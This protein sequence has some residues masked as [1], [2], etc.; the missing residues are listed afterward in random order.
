VDY[1]LTV[2]GQRI[3]VEIKYRRHIGFSDTLGLRSFVEKAHYNAPFGLLVTMLDD[4]KVEDPRIIPLP[5]STLL[6]L[7]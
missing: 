3:P 7:R 4:T 6:L 2:G 5:L 1:V